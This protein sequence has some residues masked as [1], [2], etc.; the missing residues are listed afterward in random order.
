M[1]NSQ[2]LEV[3]GVWEKSRTGGKEVRRKEGEEE[4]RR[5]GKEGRMRSVRPRL[6]PSEKSLAANPNDRRPRA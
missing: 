2:T 4:R 6:P 1:K 3:N 5:G